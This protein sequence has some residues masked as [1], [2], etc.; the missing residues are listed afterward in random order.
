MF[1]SKILQYY[2][3]EVIIKRGGGFETRKW[4]M[5]CSCSIKYTNRILSSFLNFDA[6]FTITQP[7]ENQHI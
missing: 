5:I 1:I 2:Y 7:A 6:V 4:G 3:I